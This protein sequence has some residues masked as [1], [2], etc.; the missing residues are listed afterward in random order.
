MIEKG[1]LIK[2]YVKALRFNNASIFIGSGM[3]M[4]VF[5][6]DWKELIKPYA[7]E[8]KYP[9][10]ENGNDFPLI[11][12]SYVN[13][14]N[15]IYKFKTSISEK[16]KNDTVNK[17]YITIAGLPIKNYWTTNYDCLIENAL[18][19]LDKQFDIIYDNNSFVTL[20]NKRENI[21]YKCHGDC[22]YPNSIL[23]TKEDYDRFENKSFNFT[24]ALYNEFASSTVLFLGYSFN[25]PDIKSII[26]NLAVKNDTK[27]T[28]F[29][30]IKRKKSEYSHE[31]K[32]WL[33]D[34]E[35]YGIYACLIDDYNEVE[36]IIKEIEQ[37][38]MANKVFISGS[39]VDYSQFS[40]KKTAQDF[41]HDL[42]YNLVYSD[43]SGSNKGYGL[44]IIHGCGLGIGEFLSDGIT[45]AVVENKLDVT[46]YNIP[47]PF[48]SNYYSQ[49][50]KE[51][52]LEKQYYYYRENIISKCGIA[53]FVFG[54]KYDKEGKVVNA[55]G[56]R[57]EFEIAVKQGKFV[58]PIGATG[59]M[60]K[61]LAEIVLPDF[62]KYNGDMPNIEKILREL[63]SH[64]ISAKG[65]IDRIIQIIDTLA[66][67][68]DNK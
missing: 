35:R 19:R 4:P 10:K 43:C 39:A 62:N 25:D 23:I 52:S 59:Y 13:S 53:F 8:I 48:G 41:I 60:A 68:I 64:N 15:D 55:D 21:V 33:E 5:N 9:M 54:N 12:Q 42:G 44:N 11:A 56:V 22:R 66:Y 49:F 24:H 28:H 65:I 1:Y 51:A 46:K 31:Q 67:R 6:C 14:G 50:E 61:E 63:N 34:L 20:K 58:F 16:F 2:E 38:Y 45:N 57:K 30:I 27:Q 3:S 32:F 17:F 7:E 29:I 40:D 18:N 36:V 47:C 26:S 37:Q